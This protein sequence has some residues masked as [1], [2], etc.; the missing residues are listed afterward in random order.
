MSNGQNAWPCHLHLTSANPTL[1]SG[2]CRERDIARREVSGLDSQD[3]PL[4]FTFNSLQEFREFKENQRQAKQ[5]RLQQQQQEQQQQ[6]SQPTA[7]MQEDLDS[8]RRGS[9]SQAS[10]S[11]I[12][13]SSNSS[14][15]GSSRGAG[16][17]SAGRG[18][19]SRK[20][21]DMGWVALLAATHTWL[22]RNAVL[23]CA[24]VLGHVWLKRLRDAAC[25][26]TCAWTANIVSHSS[27]VALDALGLLY[28]QQDASLKGWFC[29]AAVML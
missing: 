23:E 3:T 11:S 14:S 10:S 5:Q 18:R 27:H 16:G 13:S 24:P 28:N 1:A 21:Y 4:D 25:D 17:G 6:E 19:P 29:D 2:C 7:S 22:V 15:N 20:E 12:R 8:Q 26:M 9:S